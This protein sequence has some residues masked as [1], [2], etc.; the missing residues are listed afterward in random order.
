MFAFYPLGYLFS[1]LVFRGLA[2]GLSFLAGAGV[3]H[4]GLPLPPGGIA[5]FQRRAF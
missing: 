1:I 2:G 3:D 4:P 5:A